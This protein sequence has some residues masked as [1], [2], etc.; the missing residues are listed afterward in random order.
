MAGRRE[1]PYGRETE[2]QPVGAA[3]LDPGL[4]CG[5]IDPECFFPENLRAVH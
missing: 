5:T 4:F 2:E 1:K 3:L